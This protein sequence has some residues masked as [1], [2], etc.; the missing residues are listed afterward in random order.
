MQGTYFSL[1]SRLS[2]KGSTEVIAGAYPESR[3]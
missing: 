1:E 3:R 2:D